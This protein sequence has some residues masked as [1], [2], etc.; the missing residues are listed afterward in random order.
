MRI[1]EQRWKE[2]FMGIFTCFLVAGIGEFFEWRRGLPQQIEMNKYTLDFAGESH[3]DLFAE[4]NQELE[5]WH[6]RPR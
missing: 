3:P 1:K 4:L 5:I 2:F 6:A